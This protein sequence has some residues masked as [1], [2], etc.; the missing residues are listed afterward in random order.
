MNTFS[1][2]LGL[3]MLTL[4]SASVGFMELYFSS[5]FEA[6]AEDALVEHAQSLADLTAS[7]LGA[8]L[9]RHCP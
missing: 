1:S 4:L 3:L 8:A 6:L 5:Y 9:P 2:R 7:S